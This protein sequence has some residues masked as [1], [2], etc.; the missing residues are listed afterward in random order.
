[1]PA[2]IKEQRKVRQHLTVSCVTAARK[3]DA[4][5][6]NKITDKKQKS[7]GGESLLFLDYYFSAEGCKAAFNN[8][9]LCG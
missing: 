9:P 3:S 5:R 7:R 4:F 8:R 2:Y 1:M 6:Q